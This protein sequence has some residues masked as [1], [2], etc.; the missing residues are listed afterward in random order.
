M[1]RFIDLLHFLPEI[2][3]VSLLCALGGIVLGLAARLSRF[4][5]QCAIEDAL[6]GQDGKIIRI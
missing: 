3:I 5:T 4:C 1:I 2:E 6:Y